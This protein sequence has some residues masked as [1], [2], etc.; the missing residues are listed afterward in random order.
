MLMILDM[1]RL[2]CANIVI[3]GY[4]YILFVVSQQFPISYQ[5]F[6]LHPWPPAWWHCPNLEAYHRTPGCK[7]ARL[8]EMGSTACH[9]GRVFINQHI[10]TRE[11]QEPNSS[12]CARLQ[13]I[14]FQWSAHQKWA[15]LDSGVAWTKLQLY[16]QNSPMSWAVL[17][18]LQPAKLHELCLLPMPLPVD[19]LSSNCQP[20][21]RLQHAGMAHHPHKGIHDYCDSQEDMSKGLKM[22]QHK[23]PR[24]PPQGVNSK[25]LIMDIS[26]WSFSES[27]NTKT[28]ESIIRFSWGCLYLWSTNM[29]IHH[30]GHGY[31]HQSSSL[32][33]FKRHPNLSCA[34]MVITDQQHPIYNGYNLL[35]HNSP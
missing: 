16:I 19:V 15:A 18:C 24:A 7:T 34:G 17:L 29:M 3:T 6:H 8:R 31:S 28:I 1:L 32:W 4:K 10:V 26:E 22:W 33:D 14:S 5:L 9:E 23:R 12:T 13:R 21:T 2:S 27:T 11:I 35:I 25:R 20:F 30:N